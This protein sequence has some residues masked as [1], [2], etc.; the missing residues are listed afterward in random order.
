MKSYLLN[1]RLGY[2]SKHRQFLY[3]F[4]AL[5]IMF[6][7]FYTR[8]PLM[9]ILTPISHIQG[10]G[11]CGVEIFLILSGMGLYHS[12]KKTSSVGQFYKKRFARVFLPAMIVMAVFNTLVDESFVAYFASVT[13]FGYWLGANVIWYIPFILAMYLVYP[14]LFRIQTKRPAVMYLLLILSFV[15]SFV[16]E[17]MV[18]DVNL[19]RGISRIPVF[20]LGCIL[21]PYIEEKREV[22]GWIIPI[23]VGITVLMALPWYGMQ[24][25]RRYYFC[26]Y[27]FFRSFLFLGYA[28]VAVILVSFLA[29]WFSQHVHFHG[30]YRCIA[31][32]GAISLEIYLLYERVWMTLE[33]F[34]GF[35]S[36]PFSFIKVDMASIIITFVLAVSLQN[37][38]NLLIASFASVKIPNIEKV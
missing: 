27:Y 31:F 26:Y 35:Q 38:T 11:A 15:L 2:I 17:T 20:I 37:L 21:A 23:T 12:M 10:A 24:A 14:L 7:H 19:L 5:W 33:R 4:A 6:F 30:L 1:V 18:L 3:G 34:P 9:G 8:I 13:F 25:E 22:P 28:F 36:D 32:C 16:A 29:E